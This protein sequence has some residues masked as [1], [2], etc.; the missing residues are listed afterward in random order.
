MWS[1][2][3]AGCSCATALTGDVLVSNA[4]ELQRAL[5][6]AKPEGFEARDVTVEGNTFV[7]SLAPIAFVGV[8][9]ATVRFNTFHRPRKW[10]LRIL[11]ETRDEGFT[12]CRRGVFTDNLI[13]YRAD[14]VATIVN[15]GDATAPETFEFARNYWFC[16]DE[17]AREPPRLPVSEREAR[18][19]EDPR[20]VDAERGDV[21]LTSASPARAHGADALP[22]ERC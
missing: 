18:K 19:G 1:F 6:G 20:F 17:P 13:A 9:G 2:L 14:E 5:L 7:G 11:Q 3:L 16:I 10:V 8:D 12:P 4:D 22:R 15:V 21:S